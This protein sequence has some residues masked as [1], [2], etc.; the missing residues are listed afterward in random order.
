VRKNARMRLGTPFPFRGRVVWLTP[1]QGGRRSG[2]PATPVTDDYAATAFLPPGTVETGL[3]SFVLRVA[4]RAAWVSAADGAWLVEQ[5]IDV[6][7]GSVV[8]V[9]EGPRPVAYFHV[10]SVVVPDAGRSGRGPAAD[11]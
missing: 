2:P 10:E 4:D 9:T 11:G 8:V 3:H 6:R 1:E 5:G 7:P